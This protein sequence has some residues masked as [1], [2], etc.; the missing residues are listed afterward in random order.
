MISGDLN[1]CPTNLLLDFLKSDVYVVFGSSYI[2]G[3]LIDFLVKQKAINIHAGV[4]PYYRG[5]DCN[6]WAVADRNFHL[7]G[8]TVHLLS[9]GVDSG[10]ILFHLQHMLMAQAEYRLFPKRVI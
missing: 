9:K 7:V 1:K 4:S 5:T 10:E 3:E 6:F 2:K 8:A